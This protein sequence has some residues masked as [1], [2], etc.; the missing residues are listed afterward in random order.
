MRVY[1]YTNVAL[2]YIILCDTFTTR[3]VLWVLGCVYNSTIILL[4]CIPDCDK[5]IDFPIN[6]D[7][8]LL[9]VRASIIIYNIYARHDNMFRLDD[10]SAGVVFW[11]IGNG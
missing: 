8:I 6:V 7:I 3:I 10:G 5:N 2:V 11:A 4:L 1:V 9:F